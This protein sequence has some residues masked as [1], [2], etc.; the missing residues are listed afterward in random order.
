MTG[1]ITRDHVLRALPKHVRKTISEDGIDLLEQALSCPEAT[2]E[3]RENLL[4]YVDIIRDGKFKVTDYINAV[5]YV[6]YKLMGSSNLASYVK[7][8]PDRYQRLVDNGT[9]EKDIASH[10]SSYNKNKLVNLILE[11]TLVPVHVLNSDLYQKAI[12][13]QAEIMLSAKSDK[14]RSD[15]ANSLLIHLKP[16][17]ATKIKL[18]IGITENSA[19]DELRETTR[20]LALQ[21]QKIIESGALTARAV[22]ESKIIEGELVDASED[23]TNGRAVAE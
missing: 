1:L 5:K 14:V 4:G 3:L 10:I 18:D 8:F 7:V 13:V 12:N 20:M 15:A 17:E 6:S 9:S 22:A 19:L 21:Q 11:Q 2:E 23:Q 16:P